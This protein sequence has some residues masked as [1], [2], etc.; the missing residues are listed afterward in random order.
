MVH[1]RRSMPHVHITPSAIDRLAHRCIAGSNR[2]KQQA[3]KEIRAAAASAGIV[4]G[5]LHALY[6]D[7]AKGIVTGFT[8]PAFNVRGFS[9]EFIRAIIRASSAAHAGAFIIEIARSEIGYSEQ[10]PDELIT[11][12][13]AAALREGFVGPLFFQG[14]HYKIDPAKGIDSEVRTIEKLIDDSLQ[15]GMRHIDIDASKT[16]DLSKPSVDA[17]QLSNGTLTAHLAAYSRNQT[18]QPIV[19]GGEIGEIGGKVSTADDLRAFMG[20]VSKASG[21]GESINKVAVQTGTSHGGSVNTDGS[22]R[23]VS[24]DLRTL[25]TLSA[26]ARDEFGLAGAVQHGA[27]TLSEGQIG[28]FPDIGAAEVHLSTEFQNIIFDHPSFPVELKNDIAQY[29]IKT[30]GSERSKGQSDQQFLYRQRKHAWGP[31]K[32]QIA[33]MPSEARISIASA[34]GAK[35]SR[36][37]T[38]L[39]IDNTSDL[40]RKYHQ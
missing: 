9:Y 22:I 23:R 26:I 36:L 6:H 1:Y 39:R 4:L 14:D 8:V 25:Q 24:V 18:D 33:E 13:L 19:I 2:E 20:I 37:F 15:A 40:V 16:V 32:K 5:S 29:I 27:S 17:Q 35:I 21:S 28:S 11:V 3:R 7:M 31:F 10:S 38:A 30:F 34:I 12:G